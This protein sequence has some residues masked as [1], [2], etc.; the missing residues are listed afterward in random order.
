MRLWHKDLIA[1]LPRLQLLGQW[2]ECCLIARSIAQ[3]GSPGHL[4][5]NRVMDYPVEHFYAYALTVCREMRD[6]GYKCDFDKIEQWIPLPEGTDLSG[7]DVFPRWH[8][9]R[10][11]LQC[12]YNLQEKYDCGGVPVEDWARIVDKLW[13]EVSE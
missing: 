12:L 8:T 3:E 5:V 11:L 13:K 9:D 6:R 7:L 10:Y 1:V 4:L 2:R